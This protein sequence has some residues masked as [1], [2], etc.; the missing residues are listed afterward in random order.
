MAEDHG[1]TIDGIKNGVC[2]T[3][4]RLIPIPATARPV[5]TRDAQHRRR[6]TDPV[7]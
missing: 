4:P 2:D 6:L 7:L 1:T 5:T 3:S